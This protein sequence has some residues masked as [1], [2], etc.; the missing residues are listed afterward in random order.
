MISRYS[1]SIS[2]MCRCRHAHHHPNPVYGNQQRLVVSSVLIQCPKNL[3]EALHKRSRSD[4]HLPLLMMF[5]F[6]FFLLRKC[7]D[8]GRSG[9]VVTRERS[10]INQSPYEMNQLHNHQL[11]T[12]CSSCFCNVVVVG[13]NHKVAR[14]MYF[15][16]SF[17]PIPAPGRYII[18]IHHITA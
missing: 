1:F 2:A 10:K 5:H 3:A 11:F 7:P 14:F 13:S 6:F 4:V 15:V 12:T 16:S 9:T 18:P 17:F 8:T